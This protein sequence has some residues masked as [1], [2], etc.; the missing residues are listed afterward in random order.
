MV[1]KH[2]LTRALGYYLACQVE[3]YEA[4]HNLMGARA[5]LGMS[6]AGAQ[7]PP[8]ADLS[9]VTEYIVNGA[10]SI[11]AEMADTKRTT[12]STDNETETES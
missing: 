2:P 1:R 7:P 3:R 9:P 8:V 5:R 4:F 12:A 6:V 10:K 11:A